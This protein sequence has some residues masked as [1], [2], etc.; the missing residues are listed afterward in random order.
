[1]KKDLRLKSRYLNSK[2]KTK[3]SKLENNF[4]ETNF[5][6]ECIKLA[7]KVYSLGK[8]IENK[9][10]LNEYDYETLKHIVFLLETIGE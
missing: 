6:E 5:N 10:Y 9:D 1:M 7:K 2:G 8:E 4:I 3:M